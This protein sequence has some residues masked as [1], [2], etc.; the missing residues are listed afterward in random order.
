M[1]RTRLLDR[2]RAVL[3]VIDAQAVFLDKLAPGD[4][5][6][7]TGRIAWLMRLARLLDIPVIAMAEDLAENGPPVAEVLAE[8]PDGAPVHDKRVFGLA[9]QAD[10]LAALRATG[11][12]EAVLTG[13]E[14]DV[15]VA[16][17]ALGLLSEGLRVAVAQDATGA[18]APDHAAGLARMAA[19]GVQMMTAKSVY[20]DW[21]RDLDT[22]AKVKP[23]LGPPPEGLGL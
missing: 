7:L 16:Q 13:L 9:G 3:V 1:S 5:A 23:A 21:L 6:P 11:R 2:S 14:T 10:I 20:Y 19:A 17:S 22:L 15:C 12:D 8:L 18:P 4:R